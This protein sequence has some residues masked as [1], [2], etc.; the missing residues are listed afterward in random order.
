LGP[1]LYLPFVQRM[2]SLAPG[3]P[4]FISQTAS[5]SEY[6]SP[7]HFDPEQ[8]SRW[9]IDAYSYLTGLDGVRAILYYNID[10]GCDFSFFRSGSL[11]YEGYR[12]VVK[13]PAYGNLSP[14]EMIDAF[15]QY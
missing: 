4:I 15:S 11:Y 1:E 12:Q 2:R 6:P 9:F 8:K 10:A 13:S 5:T 3:K 14:A 7:G